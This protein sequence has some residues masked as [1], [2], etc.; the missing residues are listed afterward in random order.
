MTTCLR[1]LRHMVARDGAGGVRQGK[2]DAIEL[3][4]GHVAAAHM[5]TRPHQRAR[6]RQA[7]VSVVVTS[8]RHQSYHARAHP[9]GVSTHGEMECQGDLGA[10]TAE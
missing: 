1:L 3:R 2:E 6:D 8:Y 5:V 9:R 10:D 7:T 4:F